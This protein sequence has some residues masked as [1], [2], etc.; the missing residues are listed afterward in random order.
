MSKNDLAYEKS[1]RR[2]IKG[3]CENQRKNIDSTKLC[4]A[5]KFQESKSSAI[6]THF[7][8]FRDE[9]HVLVENTIKVLFQK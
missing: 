1:L 2:K 6:K 3:R 8:I 4:A 5:Y 9:G 7:K